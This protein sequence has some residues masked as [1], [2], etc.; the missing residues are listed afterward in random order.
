MNHILITATV[1][2]M[3]GQF[4]MDNIDILQRMGCQVHVACNFLDTSI[5]PTER[6]NMFIKKLENQKIICH[7][8]DFPRNPRFL[9][10]VIKSS[11]QLNK[12]LVHN[13]F[14][15][16]HCHTPLA[17]VVSRIVAHRRKVNVIYT[18]HGFHFYNGAP[19]VNWIFYYPIEKFLSRWTDILITIT[20]ED[21]ERAVNKFHAKRVEYVSGVGI[22]VSKFMI[23]GNER[24]QIRYSLGLQDDDIMLLSVGGLD[25]NKNHQVVIKSIKLLNNSKLRYFIAGIGPLK[26]YL[27]DLITK[28]HIE[29]NVKL[30]GYRT[31]IPK[32]LNAAD[33]YIL[34]SK[35]EGLNVSLME[36]MASG[37]PCI[38]GRIRGNVDLIQQPSG[39][40]LVNPINVD[41]Y[42]ESINHLINNNCF[43]ELGCFNR[44]IIQ[45]FDIKVIR[46]RMIAIYKSIIPQN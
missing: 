28:C 25:N 34:P 45:N 7:Q 6:I 39:G 16:I 37:L 27:L 1:P 32:L 13:S 41:D 8:I 33:V 44:N 5:W 40:F 22:D 42:I 24:N 3:I 26:D 46:E 23:N 38:C 17:G 20:K 18:A 14:K 35:R 4:N 31:D 2:S 9:F 19:L 21:F 10:K 43:S 11:R 30:L 29:N 12:L 36:A 15:L